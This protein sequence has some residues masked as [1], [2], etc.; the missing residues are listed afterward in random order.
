MPCAPAPAAES[1]DA[2]ALWASFVPA[3]RTAVCFGTT[4]E[5][6]HL[7]AH[8]P[9]GLVAAIGA[10]T[11]QYAGRDSRERPLLLLPLVALGLA[12]CMAIGCVG[13]HRGLVVPV[14]VAA[15]TFLAACLCDGLAV[16]PPG[17]ATFVLACAIG[18][19]L[20]E[21]QLAAASLGVLVVGSVSAAVAL[22]D[23]LWRR[24][25]NAARP[26]PKTPGAPFPTRILRWLNLNYL[27]SPTPFMALRASVAVLASGLVAVAVGLPRPYWGMAAAATVF[28]QGSY[29]SV[30][31]ERGLLRMGGTL[32]GVPVAAAIVRLDPMGVLLAVTLAALVLSSEVLVTRNYALAMAFATPLA[33]V[34]TNA[35][36][37]GQSSGDL[38]WT[39]TAETAVGCVFGVVAG[40]LV[41]RRWAV[42]QLRLA[43]VAARDAMVDLVAAS[44]VDQV[45]ARRTTLN[46]RMDRLE[47]VAY[48]TGQERRS[49]REAVSSLLP[50]VDVTSRLGARI[51]ACS[52]NGST[53]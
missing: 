8:T 14:V 2:A 19:N 43:L 33:L 31:S 10:L 48:R 11:L 50:V 32:I 51:Q 29:A 22:S 12:G 27:R 13:G 24:P 37:H 21:S 30:T 42:K 36:A 16:P 45:A 6:A 3:G 52:E 47:R 17:M 15:T 4:V 40:L 20:P 7:L 44:D 26:G 38:L 34:L 28:A 25:A 53:L 1:S 46:F 39:R 18:T 41:T 23:R 35:A 5:L 9:I 49:V